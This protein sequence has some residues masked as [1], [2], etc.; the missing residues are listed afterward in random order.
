MGSWYRSNVISVDMSLMH[1]W[2]LD[3]LFLRYIVKR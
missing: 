2:E 3:F 1:S